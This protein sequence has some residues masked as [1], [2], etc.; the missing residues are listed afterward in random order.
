MN[1]LVIRNGR[2]VDP[3]QNLDEVC[4]IKIEDG[5]I[6]E[7]GSGLSGDEA[8]DASGLVV[9]PGLVDM[10]VHLRDPGLTYK[11]DILSGCT[12]AAAGGV[13]SVVCMP[14]TK[15]AADRPEVIRYIIE[16]AGEASAKVYPAAAITMDLAGEEMTDF[17][18]LKKAGAVAVSD[19]GRPV[20]SGAMMQKALERA[21]AEGLLVTS[22]C[23]DLRIIDGG[24]IHKGKASETLGV[25]GMDRSSEDSVTAREIALAAATGTAVH[26]AH[27]STRGSV[28]LI[29]DAKARGVRVTAETAP[30]YFMLTDELLMKRDADYRMNPPLREQADCDAVLEGLLDGT[31]DCIVTD[32]APHAPEE[33]ADFLKAPNGV[34]GLETSFAACATALVH[35]G[36]MSLAGLIRRMSENPARILGIPAGSLK[37]GMPADLALFDLDE[38][39]TVDPDRFCSKSRNSVFKGMTLRG[40][41]KYTLLDGR[42]V[43]RDHEE[44]GGAK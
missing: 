22:H 20:E 14:N 35:T 44:K 17:A 1:T 21:C 42:I 8:L 27:V 12:A 9:A 36:K 7:I 2:V 11:E 32:H 6:A 37:A 38:C 18:A 34:V 4:D 23:E 39:W 30:H 19:D 3:S 40:K 5:K 24:I 13:T 43:Y 25:K 15:P 16:K 28:A 29:R 33:K 10:H 41:I 31:L 26:I